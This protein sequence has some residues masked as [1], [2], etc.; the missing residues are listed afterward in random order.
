MNDYVFSKNNQGIRMS[1]HRIVAERYLRR[2]LRP[3]EV[4]HHINTNREDNVIIN[5]IV[6]ETQADHMKFHK[7][8]REGMRG[9]TAYNRNPDKDR[10]LG[11]LY[12]Y[13][14]ITFYGPLYQ[15]DIKRNALNMA[16]RMK[17]EL[18]LSNITA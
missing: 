4:V 16:E 11:I 7:H 3:E 5:L 14:G 13:Y 17:R 6:F 8:R 1:Q 18:G 9:I 15:S 2:P 10:L 12:K